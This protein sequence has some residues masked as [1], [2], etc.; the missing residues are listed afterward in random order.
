MVRMVNTNGVEA[1][2]NIK[3]VKKYAI[4]IFSCITRNDE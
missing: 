1:Y 2:D 4:N 3:K